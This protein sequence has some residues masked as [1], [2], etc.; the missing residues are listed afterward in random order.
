MVNYGQLK[1][2]KVER[3][4]RRATVQAFGNF[5]QVFSPSPQPQPLSS[6]LQ[7]WVSQERDA[8]WVCSWLSV[9]KDPCALALDEQTTCLRPLS[10]PHQ[11]PHVSFQGASMYPVGEANAHHNGGEK[12]PKSLFPLKLRKFLK[13]KVE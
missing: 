10:A 1:Q 11:K 5:R 2:R 3:Q 4:V 12:N 7:R 8:R 6:T 9:S 13:C